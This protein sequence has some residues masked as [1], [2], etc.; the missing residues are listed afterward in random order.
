[1]NTHGPENQNPHA[2]KRLTPPSQRWKYRF[3]YFLVGFLLGYLVG[4]ART[5]VLVNTEDFGIEVRFA[6]PG[7]VIHAYNV[8]PSSTVVVPIHEDVYSL[9]GVFKSSDGSSL[10]G[11][12]SIPDGDLLVGSTWGASAIA[13][14]LGSPQPATGVPIDQQAEIFLYGFFAMSAWEIFGLMWRLFK[15]RVTD[16]FSQ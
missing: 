1:M 13:Q 14:T 9:Y 11:G 3:I 8:P 12:G 4:H 10:I 7:S 16:S 2:P 15:N 6:L 5:A